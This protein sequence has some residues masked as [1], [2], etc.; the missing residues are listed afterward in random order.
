VLS[1]CGDWDYPAGGSVGLLGLCAMGS[2]TYDLPAVGSLAQGAQCARHVIGCL[3]WANQ[4]GA[5]FGCP[6]VLWGVHGHNNGNWQAM[7]GELV[8]LLYIISA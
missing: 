3:S 2:K 1:C 7:G 5:P 6:A 4:H 8:G